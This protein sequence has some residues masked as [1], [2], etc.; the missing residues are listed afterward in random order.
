MHAKQV[1]KILKLRNDVG[2]SKHFDHILY[3]TN[4]TCKQ[5]N[6]LFKD[7]AGRKEEVF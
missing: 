1:Q 2:P 4:L 7:M 5:A 6:Q 3:A